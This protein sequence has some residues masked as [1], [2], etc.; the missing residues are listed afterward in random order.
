[1]AAAL[2]SKEEC[3]AFP[4]FL[5]LLYWTGARDRRELP[6]IGVMLSLSIAAGL[7]VVIAG[8]APPGSGIASQAGI[9]ALSYWQTQGSVILRYLRQL[10]LP[11][12]FSVDPDIHIDTGVLA[13]AAW[14][15]ILALVWLASRRFSREHAGFWFLGGVLL[16]L[17]SSSIFPAADLA[18]DRRMY[19][20]LIA[21]SAAL[22]I[23]AV[24]MKSRIGVIIGIAVLAG[25]SL[26]RTLVWRTE[27]ALW[28]DAAA[29]APRKIRPKIQLARALGGTAGLAIL[30]EADSIAPDDPRVASEEGRIAISLSN[31][32]QALVAFGRALA[33]DPSNAA[34]QSNRGVAL[35]MLGQTDAA[36]NDF[37]RALSINPCQFD[38]RLNLLRLGV[39]TAP[40]AS[41]RFSPDQRAAL[42]GI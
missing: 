32:Q 30:A 33:L 29:K 13:Y 42:R 31:P 24:A 8:G 41:C 14:I 34:A 12:G 20:P 21:F 1:F 4:L 25:L 35:L 6:P 19:L 28:T 36:R 7:R 5:L 23:V 38:A 11:W 10:I 16:L 15:A 26:E 2:L 18:A 17:P 39:S 40:P 3:V 9:S 27:L 37:E 22:G